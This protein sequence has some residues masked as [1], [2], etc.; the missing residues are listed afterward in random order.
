MYVQECVVKSETSWTV[1]STDDSQ[2]NA[3][4]AHQWQRNFVGSVCGSCV[5][6]AAFDRDRQQRQG[7]RARKKLE[8]R[9]L[10]VAVAAGEAFGGTPIRRARAPHF[11]PTGG[12]DLRLALAAAHVF[13]QASVTLPTSGAAPC[14]TTLLLA[15]ASRPTNKVLA[16]FNVSRCQWCTAV[17]DGNV[18][19]HGQSALQ[20]K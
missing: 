20:I 14:H 1:V 7:T 18:D 10:A 15:A 5:T 12:R 19:Q 3:H 9:S 11:G 4:N 8:D 2:D 17:P 13:D 6:L 16:T